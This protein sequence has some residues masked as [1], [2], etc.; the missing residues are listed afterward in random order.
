VTPAEQALATL[1][2]FQSLT[3]EGKSL[4]ADIGKVLRNATISRDIDGASTLTLDLYDNARRLLRSGLFGDRTTMQV[5]M[6][7]F[8]LAQVRK[9]GPELTCVFEDLPVAALRR[10]DEPVKVAPNTTT[11]V[12]FAQRLV[13]EEAWLNFSTPDAVRTQE[14]AKIE[15]ARGNPA[16]PNAE[17]EDTWSAI[18]RLAADRGWRRYVADKNTI[19]Y[20]PETYLIDQPPAYRF[21][22][23][24]QGVEDINFD[25]DIGKPVATLKVKVRASRWAVPVGTC[26]EVYDLGPVNGKW[27]VSNIGRSIFSLF[28]DVTLTRARPTLP[29]PEPAPAPSAAELGPESGAAGVGAVQVGSGRQQAV[30]G[31]NFIWPVSGRISSGFGPRRSPG[32]I[33]SK[34]HAGIDIAASSGTR[35]NAAKTGTVIHAGDAGGYGKAV[36]I[37]HGG[38]IVTRYAHLSRITTRRGVRVGQGEQIGT[39]GQTGTATGPHLHFEVRVGGVARNPTEYLP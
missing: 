12:D 36:Y 34:N 20:V 31:Q 33:G 29:E 19:A 25:F 5:D 24:A 2:G 3:M 18:G 10:R 15:L 16:D 32:G 22:E 1:A 13:K 35:V 37:D 21:T 26:V 9:A 28:L 38:G 17:R 11:H 30:S 4:S 8:E 6:W 27:I 14:R 7:S 39:V 23:H